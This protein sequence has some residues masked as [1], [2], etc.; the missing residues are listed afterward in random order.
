MSRGLRRILGAGWIVALAVS[1]AA[2]YAQ[3]S[4]VGTWKTIDDATGKARALVRITEQDGVFSGRIEKLLPADQPQ[5][6]VCT[7]CTDE[8]SGQPIVG[9]TILRKVRAH[10]SE[11]RLWEGGDVLDPETGKVYRG[12][13][14]LRDDNTLELRGYIGVPL[15]GRTQ[16][17]LREQTPSS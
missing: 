8:R 15:F 16:V 4:I 10:P 3:A 7:A 1:C 14:R 2:A 13:I 5:D 12:R 9:M 11:P 6:P 17:W